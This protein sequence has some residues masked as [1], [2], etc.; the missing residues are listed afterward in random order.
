MTINIQVLIK[1][2][3]THIPDSAPGHNRGLGEG[4]SEHFGDAIIG[5]DV[6]R[7]RGHIVGIVSDCCRPYE[8][9]Y[10]LMVNESI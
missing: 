8:Q 6:E 4:A 7:F 3:A 1:L 5:N 10:A 9:A 2:D